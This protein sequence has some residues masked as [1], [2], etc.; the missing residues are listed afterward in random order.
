MKILIIEDSDEIIESLK[1]A[2]AKTKYTTFFKKTIKSAT[3]FLK[4]HLID[5]IIL[6][7]TLPDGN[8]YSLYV[9][10]IKKLNI[11]TIFLTAHDSEDDIV[12]G[13]K[14]GAEDYIV[15]PFSIRELI[16]RVDRVL[17]NK[18][19]IIRIKDIEFN[20]DKMLICKNNNP[21]P[22]TS[23]ELKILTLLFTYKNKVVTRDMLLDCIYEIT[24]NEVDN[25]TLTV[26]MKRIR[27]KLGTDIITTIKG[28]GYIID[29]NEESN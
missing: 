28:I 16:A 22:I 1:Y 10:N 19:V 13:L 6:D 4:S 12:K 23:L 9:N 26:Y 20:S 29:T 2:F 3:E 27:E 14:I 18:N 7:I 8:G 24:G 17:R 15:K 11:P 21:L 25:H 5:L